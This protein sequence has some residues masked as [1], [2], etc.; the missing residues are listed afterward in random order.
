MQSSRAREGI[1]ICIIVALWLMWVGL[2]SGGLNS[3][4]GVRV[5]NGPR[6]LNECD[7]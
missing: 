4:P 1:E 5:Y 6:L 3:I 7:V 2:E